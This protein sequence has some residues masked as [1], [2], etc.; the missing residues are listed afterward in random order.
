MRKN[1]KCEDDL[2][3]TFLIPMVVL[4]LAAMA[5]SASSIT[6]LLENAV[7]EDEG[8]LLDRVSQI[9][10]QSEPSETIVTGQILTQENFSDP[11]AWEYYVDDG[12][13][14]QVD[15]GAYNM[16]LEVEGFIWGINEQMHS[17][18]V[19][20]VFA[21]QL[22]ATD[23]N[24][25]G[26]VCRS[27]T[28]NMGNGYYFLI[29]GDGFYSIM[30]SL[31]DSAEALVDWTSSSQIQQGRAINWIK[32]VCVENYLALFIND[33]FVAEAYDSTFSEGYAGLSV[34]LF[35]AGNVEVAFD[36]LI[37]LAASLAE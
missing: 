33:T 28:E 30:K 26:V 27:D 3:K 23:N 1:Q 4:A 32:A 12:A 36:D 7:S 17:D 10:P 31:D 13:A 18:V 8:S 2:K 22:S 11:E 25:Y 9:L 20:T 37:I 15:Q 5:C 34:A 29:S 35:E 14:L 19:I 6:S 21:T 24:G 16:Y